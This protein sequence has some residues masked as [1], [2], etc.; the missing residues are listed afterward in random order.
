MMLI[1]GELIAV[2]VSVVVMA[3]AV[4]QR[5]GPFFQDG[6]QSFILL[7]CVIPATEKYDGAPVTNRQWSRP[8]DCSGLY[9]GIGIT[10]NIAGDLFQAWNSIERPR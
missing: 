3:A 2:P 5:A 6:F 9:S 10:K 7:Y 8:G 1:H 4:R